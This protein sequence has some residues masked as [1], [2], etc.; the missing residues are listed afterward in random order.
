MYAI[1]T[2]LWKIGCGLCLKKG[3][4]TSEFVRILY[5]NINEVCFLNVFCSSFFA[6]CYALIYFY[7][8]WLLYCIWHTYENIHWRYIKAVN[9]NSALVIYLEWTLKIYE[10]TGAHIVFVERKACYP[11]TCSSTLRINVSLTLFDTEFWRAKI[12]AV[13]VENILL[14]NDIL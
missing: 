10:N 7:F 9:S 11:R 13:V 14:T 4:Y 3:W 6:W 12:L 5:F 2:K 1:T 8:M